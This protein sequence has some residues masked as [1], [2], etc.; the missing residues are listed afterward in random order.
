MENQPKFTNETP[1]L[2]TE[3]CNSMRLTCAWTPEDTEFYF[4]SM[5][6]VQAF[7]AT[8]E[9][10]LNEVT[11]SEAEAF[12][13][14]EEH[15]STEATVSE[16]TVSE[17]TAFNKQY[18]VNYNEEQLKKFKKYMDHYGL[19][20][21]DAII[22]IQSCHG[23]DEQ[24]HTFAGE[25]CSGGCFYHVEELGLPCFRGENC[26]ICNH[27]MV[28]SSVASSVA[29]LFIDLES[30]LYVADAG[31]SMPELKRSSKKP[32]LE[33][34]S[35]TTD[36][37]KEI[38]DFYKTIFND[39]RGYIYCIEGE[40]DYTRGQVPDNFRIQ[41]WIN[42]KAYS[43]KTNMSC[44]DAMHYINNCHCCG[45]YMNMAGNIYC[46]TECK[47]AIEKDNYCCYNN[48]RNK[49]NINMP[50][51]CLIC[52]NA[53]RAR[54]NTIPPFVERVNR[55]CYLA[56]YSEDN[57][58]KYGV[59]TFR[60]AEADAEK[61]NITLLD[62]FLGV[63]GVDCNHSLSPTDCD[64]YTCN[65]ENCVAR[66]FYGPTSEMIDNL[67]TSDMADLT[68][69]AYDHGVELTRAFQD[70]HVC[71]TCKKD[72][73]PQTFGP[74]HQFCSARCEV[75]YDT[76][77][78]NDSC[79]R[80]EGRNQNCNECDGDVFRL[81]REIIKRE[82]DLKTPFISTIN[83]LQDLQVYNQLDDTLIDL[84]EYLC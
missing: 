62:A 38:D 45:E 68:Q 43:A 55:F 34:I 78:F 82:K 77:P 3:Q 29:S 19:E 70:Q 2:S 63:I 11:V 22:Y 79:S 84:V 69:Y 80:C 36:Y 51:D 71:R 57:K 72:V 75:I 53:G 49:K 47:T 66:P 46:S 28:A 16:A 32:V 17:V 64:E 73:E 50:R 31:L 7:D 15:S 23:C 21:N 39:G 61:Y 65:Y 74:S 58:Y 10:S 25:Y 60:I 13:A 5:I 1:E 18:R 24:I 83:A 48:V 37:L 81:C 27:Q 12:D 42:L 30:G 33:D 8:E 35:I 20:T 41:N 52:L 54:S 14:T 56:G 59:E 9:H 76:R 44:S 40:K 6:D 4:D 26:L 67:S